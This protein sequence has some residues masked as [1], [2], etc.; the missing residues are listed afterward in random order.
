MPLKERAPLDSS[1]VLKQTTENMEQAIFNLLDTA[2]SILPTLLAHPV[3][4]IGCNPYRYN[5][6]HKWATGTEPEALSFPVAEYDQRNKFVI[7]AFDE[8]VADHSE[9][10]KPVR[11]R[12]AFC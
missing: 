12:N 5:L 7:D 1:G 11:L 4:E 6:R 2:S 10:I 9:R 8:Y 3:P